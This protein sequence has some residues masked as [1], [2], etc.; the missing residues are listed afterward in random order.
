MDDTAKA[1]AVALCKQW[2]LDPNKVGAITIKLRPNDIAR[3]EVEVQGGFPA[4]A[5]ELKR[6]RLVQ[7]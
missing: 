6:Y 2:H 7:H 5:T 1:I 3:V 4:I